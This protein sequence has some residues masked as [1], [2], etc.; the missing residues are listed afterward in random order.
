MTPEA[1][2]ACFSKPGDGYHFARWGRAIA[3]VV[4]GVQEQTL[5]VLKGALEAIMVLADHKMTEVDPEIG[6]NLIMFFVLDWQEL[7][8]T[9]NLEKLIPDM[10]GLVGRLENAG[11]NQYR[12]FRCDDDGAIQACFVFLRM[13]ET[14]SQVPAESLALNQMVLA[15]LLWS[16]QA[17]AKSSPLARI[18][19]HEGVILRPEIGELIRAA[20]DPVLPAASRDPSHAM[21]LF[22]RMDIAK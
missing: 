9:P 3:P 4:F 6:A 14:L 1:V 16:E 12:L 22:A 11:A 17:F 8:Q 15:S 13:D 10:T 19:D 20:Y 2:E 5:E 21:R 18:S 7:V